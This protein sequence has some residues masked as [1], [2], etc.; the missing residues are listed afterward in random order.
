M[1]A[2]IVALIIAG[3]VGMSG[4]MA[5]AVESPVGDLQSGTT[6]EEA[7]PPAQVPL[8]E[9]AKGEPAPEPVQP[10][11][12][13]PAERLHFSTQDDK[14]E[15]LEYDPW[16]PM[17]EK[18]FTFNH[19]VF[20]RFLVKPL[21]TAWDT[22]MPD[23]FQEGLANAFDNLAM[24]R[25]VVNNLLQGKFKR[26]GLEVTR[27][28]VNTVFGVG[29]F[30]D[31]AKGSG[32]EKHDE[33]TGQTL[34]FY[35]VH[36]GPYLVLPF[37]APLTVRDGVGYVADLAL[38][39]LNYFIPFGASLGRRGGEI[40]NTRSQNLEFFESVEEST[41]DLYTAVRNAYLQRRQRAIE[42]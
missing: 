35:G 15:M 22:V 34:G 10:T 42:E 6:V 30:I 19:R 20:D 2:G 26:A 7:A 29:G 21:A 25:R 32:L 3:L 12:P 40:V 41:V 28:L 37:L 1:V 38:D 31:I 24:P 36:P 9:G 23:L 27:F 16:E 18:T 13:A 8:V 14:E 4:A 33:D 17:N 11:N 5:E 39:P